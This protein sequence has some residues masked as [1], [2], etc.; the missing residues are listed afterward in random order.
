M[1]SRMGK[2]MT[3]VFR[4]GVSR[5]EIESIKSEI[6]ELRGSIEDLEHKSRR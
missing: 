4:T 2:S 1:T 6:S 5:E 3:E